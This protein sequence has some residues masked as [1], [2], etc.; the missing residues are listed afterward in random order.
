MTV[1]VDSAQNVCD[2]LV[3]GGVMAIWNFAPVHLQL[4][5][6][7]I[8]Q[9]ENLAARLSGLSHQIVRLVYDR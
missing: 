7:I 1:P 5:E 4:P 3:E 6:H 9:N 2:M 8:I